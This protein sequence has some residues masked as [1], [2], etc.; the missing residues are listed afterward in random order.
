MKIRIPENPI[1]IV[2]RDYLTLLT[3]PGDS[4]H[5]SY[6]D[7]PPNTVSRAYLYLQSDANTVRLALGK[8]RTTFLLIILFK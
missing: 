6:S 4:V 7:I 5:Q 3:G 8:I 1:L 2:L